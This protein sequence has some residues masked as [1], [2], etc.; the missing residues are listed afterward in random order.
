MT[1]QLGRLAGRRIALGI[2]GSIAAY[3]AVE[4]VRLGEA[5]AACVA[6]GSVRRA[7]RGAPRAGHQAVVI[8]GAATGP[9]PPGIRIGRRRIART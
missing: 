6:R 5:S 2:T 7:S 8:N 1:E 9:V 3:K 4:L